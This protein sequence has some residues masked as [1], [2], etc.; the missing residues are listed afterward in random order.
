M[1][2]DK[3]QRVQQRTAVRLDPR[4]RW[5]AG[6][7]G[8]TGMGSGGAAVYIT[9]LEAGPV[10]LIAAGVL[11]M[12]ISLGA[13]M[14][15]RLKFGDNEASSEVVGDA[16]AQAAEDS[17]SESRPELMNALGKISESAPAAAAPALD[18]VA[19]ENMIMEMLHDIH[20]RAL[21][22]N[23]LS[24]PFDLIVQPQNSTG[25]LFDAYLISPSQIGVSVEIR[26]TRLSLPVA[27]LMVSRF[28]L[29]RQVDQRAKALL[30]IGRYGPTNDALNYLKSEDVNFSFA[31]IATPNDKWKLANDIDNLFKGLLL[32]PVTPP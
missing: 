17:S 32:P 29:L 6:L 10:A 12:F 21:S 9:H 23:G 14:P 26:A 28:R 8:L 19:Y 7:L 16:L 1:P 11:F 5:A 20:R 24:Q 3:L 22:E 4:L 25:I 30:F 27:T 13:L 2:D 31:R 18:A 15:T